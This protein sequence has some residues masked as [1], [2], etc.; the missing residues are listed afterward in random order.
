LG[1]NIPSGSVDIWMNGGS[2]QPGCDG[3]TEPI[4]S[5]SRAWKYYAESVGSKGKRFYGSKCKNAWEC[6]N[7][8]CLKEEKIQSVGLDINYS[9]RGNYY[10]ETNSYYPYSKGIEGA[11]CSEPVKE[12]KSHNNDK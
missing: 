10:L 4:C 7:H 3:I 8:N 6:Q 1:A 12:K 11:N 2:E 5:H 9:L